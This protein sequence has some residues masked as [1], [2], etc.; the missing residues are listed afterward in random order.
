MTSP[1]TPA[2]HAG[3]TGGP[4]EKRTFSRRL[5]VRG[6]F[7]VAAIAAI[8]YGTHWWTTARFLESTDDAYVGG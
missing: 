2:Q 7:V 4:S 8:G 5:A 6:A 3:Q 1:S